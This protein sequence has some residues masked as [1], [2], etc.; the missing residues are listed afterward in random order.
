MTDDKRLERLAGAGKIY[1]QDLAL[2]AQSTTDETLEAI[3]RYFDRPYYNLT[4]DELAWFPEA[5]AAAGLELLRRAG[6]PTDLGDLADLET[7]FQADCQHQP[8]RPIRLGSHI[9]H[10]KAV[11]DWSAADTAYWKK[12]KTAPEVRLFTDEKL[13]AAYRLQSVSGSLLYA[14]MKKQTVAVFAESI[15]LVM[16]ANRAGAFEMVKEGEGFLRRQQE[17]GFRRWEEDQKKHLQWRSW[18]ATEKKDNPAFAKI[19]SKQGQARIL[20]KKH[21]IPDAVATIAKQLSPL[22]E[23][24]KKPNK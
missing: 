15:K 14:L 9:E 4:D 23:K 22:P 2:T 21:E 5:I 7:I 3:D 19:A 1:V 6:L 16:L 24:R 20:K 11:A 8:R 17:S 12:L 10:D 13:I 18:Q